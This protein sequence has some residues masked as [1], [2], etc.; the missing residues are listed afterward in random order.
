MP[1]PVLFAGVSCGMD[2]V[3]IRTVITIG[4]QKMMTMTKRRRSNHDSTGQRIFLGSMSVF[5]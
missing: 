2:N 1:S 4:I 5:F 3:K